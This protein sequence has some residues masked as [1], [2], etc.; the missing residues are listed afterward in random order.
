MNRHQLA[1]AHGAFD[2][3]AGAWPLISLRSFE[4]VTGPK[5]DGWLVKT[6]G[7]LIT[8]VGAALT[9]AGIRKRVTPEIALLAIATS[10]GLTLIDL[11][12]AGVRARIPRVYLLDAL[13]ELGIIGAW[14]LATREGTDDVAPA[15]ADVVRDVW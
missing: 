15:P 9:T 3:A 8:A 4:A 1:I 2:I 5:L 12:Y 13:G 11:Y 7:L 14:V 10:A 6:A